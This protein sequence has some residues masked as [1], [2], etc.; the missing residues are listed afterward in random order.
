MTGLEPRKR[1]M[2]GLAAKGAA[3]GSKRRKSPLFIP[4]SQSITN[5]STVHRT[6]QAAAAPT[7][8]NAIV[9]IQKN[10]I[11]RQS[12]D[13]GQFTGQIGFFLTLQEGEAD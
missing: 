7:I 3:G 4:E 12:F 8:P 2:I 11:K 10:A 13:N 6:V 9:K 1:A 5:A